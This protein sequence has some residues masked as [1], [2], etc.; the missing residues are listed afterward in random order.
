MGEQAIIQMVMT[1]Y[2]FAA[3]GVMIITV[4]VGLA[5]PRPEFRTGLAFHGNPCQ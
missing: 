1:I 4:L 3:F 2:R 5:Y